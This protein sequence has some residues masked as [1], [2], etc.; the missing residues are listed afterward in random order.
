MLSS[1]CDMGNWR[2]THFRKWITCDICS[3]NG[4]EFSVLP[5]H[6][7]CVLDLLSMKVL[8]HTKNQQNITH[9]REVFDLFCLKSFYCTFYYCVK[10]L[11]T[12]VLRYFFIPLHIYM[13]V[14]ID[15]T[16]F[17]L[18]RTSWNTFDATSPL[19][20]DPLETTPSFRS[21]CSTLSYPTPALSIPF[22]SNWPD[23]LLHF[24]KINYLKPYLNRAM[25]T[26]CTGGTCSRARLELCWW[27]IRIRLSCPIRIRVLL[28]IRI[29]RGTFAPS[30]TILF[31]T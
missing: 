3:R 8:L 23:S 26:I 1:F 31:R 27:R 2:L 9:V 21:H 30:L 20:P 24:H 7:R 18:F 14:L 28:F 11:I 16:Y 17:L 22:S 6:I 13:Y 10:F 25:S 5:R 12:V 4:S 19:S 15:Q 29:W